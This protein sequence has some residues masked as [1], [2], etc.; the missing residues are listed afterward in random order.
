MLFRK[1]A[2]RSLKG[3]K[4]GLDYVETDWEAKEIGLETTRGIFIDGDPNLVY[5]TAREIKNGNVGYSMVVSFAENEEELKQKLARKGKDIYDLWEEIKRFLFYGYKEGEIAYSVVAHRGDEG[6]PHKKEHENFHFHIHIANR[7]LGTDKPL[8]FW[9]FQKDLDLFKAYIDRKYGFKSPLPDNHP[10]M[11][12]PLERLEELLKNRLRKRKEYLETL[13]E[14]VNRD[15]NGPDYPLP[16]EQPPEPHPPRPNNSTHAMRGVNAYGSRRKKEKEET[17]FWEVKSYPHEEP[18]HFLEVRIDLPKKRRPHLFENVCIKTAKEAKKMRK[19]ARTLRQLVELPN[20]LVYL[21]IPFYAGVR[22]DGKPYILARVPWRED[23]NPSFYAIKGDEG[24]WRWYDLARKESGTVIDFVQR[25][26]NLSFTEVLDFLTQHLE[27]IKQ[28][29]PQSGKSLTPSLKVE[30]KDLKNPEEDEDAL[31][32]LENLWKLKKFP[33]NLK[34]ATLVLRQKKPKEDKYG[35][36]RLVEVKKE[37][38]APVMV[39]IDESG[40]PVYWRDINPA[41]EG[42]GFLQPNIPRLRKGKAKRLYVVEG[43]TDFLTLYQVDPE[44]HFL[45]LGTVENTPKAIELLKSY[46]TYKVY[47]A[48]DNDRAGRKATEVL[49]EHLPEA[50]DISDLY[51]SYKDFAEFWTEEGYDRVEEIRRSLI[52]APVYPRYRPYRPKRDK[53]DFSPGM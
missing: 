39:W 22:S 12:L 7:L 44:A 10:Y 32:W 49:K 14:R 17:F 16:F 33:E 21:G 43:F 8:K 6:K 47:L 13:Y 46:N 45:I 5:Q 42:K 2:I 31:L 34:T 20:L 25:L 30:V 1:T 3:L 4:A 29:N 35:R 11:N 40:K 9:F 48:L 27:E 53:D 19:N 26:R 50:K 41:K 15:D 28:V 23:K 37:K 51:K 18:P 24:Y 36:V 38:P 52:P